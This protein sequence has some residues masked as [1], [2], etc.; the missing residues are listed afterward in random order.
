MQQCVEVAQAGTTCLVRDT[1]NCTSAPLAIPAS[2]W[3]AFTR[4]VK[5]GD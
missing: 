1:R 3:T 5:G 2:V 4:S